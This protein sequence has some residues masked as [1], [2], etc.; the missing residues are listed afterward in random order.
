MPLHPGCKCRDCAAFVP[1]PCKL[2]LQ[3]AVAVALYTHCGVDFGGGLCSEF[4]SRG[5]Q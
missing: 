3:C 2:E 1:M 5:S 4:L